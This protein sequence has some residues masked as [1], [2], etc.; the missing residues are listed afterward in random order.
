MIS[1]RA[2]AIST[3]ALVF[4]T[5]F[6]PL[7]MANSWTET[8]LITFTAS[9]ELPGRTLAAGTYEFRL[10][11]P[12]LDPNLV[13]IREFPSGQVV[14]ILSTDRDP[15]ENPADKPMVKLERTEPGAPEAIKEWFYPGDTSGHKFIYPKTNKNERK[16]VAR[17][18]SLPDAMK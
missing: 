9:V 14:A 8:T 16:E 15:L 17:S 2:I 11:N 18:V 4:V 13:E 10:V 7:A 1:I 5:L 6:S 12:A 3:W